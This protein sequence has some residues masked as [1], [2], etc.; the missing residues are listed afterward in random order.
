MKNLLGVSFTCVYFNTVQLELRTSLT[1]TYWVLDLMFR[2]YQWIHW[3]A[4]YLI[5]LCRTRGWG[6][7]TR[8]RDR[9]RVLRTG[10]AHHFIRW[11]FRSGAARP[12]SP[13]TLDTHLTFV[14]IFFWKDYAF[15]LF[16]SATPISELNMP[17]ICN[18]Q[19]HIVTGC[20]KQ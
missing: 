12:E 17:W 5:L 11:S 1:E 3:P 16:C 10:W 8:G 19:W 2:K 14:I 9:A 18:A 13:H 15:K 20:F 4:K 7:L 6:I